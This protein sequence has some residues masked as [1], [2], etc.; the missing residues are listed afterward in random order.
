VLEEVK[1]VISMDCMPIIVSD[2]IE[3]E[4]PVELAIDMP[5]IVLVG[6]MALVELTIVISMV[7]CVRNG[8]KTEVSPALAVSR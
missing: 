1:N 5:D 2:D 6:N 3:V 8:T 7:D 4:E